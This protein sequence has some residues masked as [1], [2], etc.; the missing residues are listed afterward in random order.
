MQQPRRLLQR[1]YRAALVAVN[2]RRC[3]REALARQPLPGPVHLIALGKAAEAM[4]EGASD[5]LGAA[6]VRGLLITKSGHADPVIWRNRPVQL[7]ESAHPI[8]DQRS[9]EAG[10]ALLEFIDAA[11]ADAQFLFLLSGGASSLVE[12]LPAGADVGELQR[13]NRYLLGSGLDIHAV[14]RLRQA[15][16][17]IK[18][19]R[20]ARRLDGRRALV[21]LISDV[22]GD[23]P[24]VIGSGPLTA[25]RTAPVAAAELPPE[26]RPLLTTEPAPPLGDPVFENIR[27]EIVAS[28]AQALAAAAERAGELGFEVHRHAE[29][30]R[31]EAVDIG[32]ALARV[33]AAGP[34]G[35]HLWGGEPTV[36]LPPEP[37]RGGRMQGLALAA[38]QAIEGR[39]GLY[40]LAAGSDGSDGPT[41]DAGALI[42]GG[43]VARCRAGGYEPAAALAAADAGS[44]LA[45]SGDLLYTGP[46]GT[47]VMDL[48][49]GLRTGS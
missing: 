29:F 7:L 25:S 8:P 16:S 17:L 9:L 15:C 13:L 6:I 49:I 20:L 42:D 18:G 3:V 23:D 24:A 37:G 14:N 4:A 22:E 41:E 43:T 31:G 2:G 39:S 33:L 36:T 11:P 12:V 44:A 38:A 47:N 48:V 45:A 10:A 5:Q 27:L 46:T 21:L 40:L 30:I 32:A 34:A 28:N 19:G 35:I 1:I 26:L